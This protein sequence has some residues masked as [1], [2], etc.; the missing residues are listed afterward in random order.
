MRGH[1]RAPRAAHRSRRVNSRRGAAVDARPVGSFRSTSRFGFIPEAELSHAVQGSE[2]FEDLVSHLQDSP[3]G[4][5]MLFAMAV[6]HAV[7]AA[8]AA[9]FVRQL[10]DA[11]KAAR[12]AAIAQARHPQTSCIVVC[13]RGNA[14]DNLPPAVG[15]VPQPRIG[16]GPMRFGRAPSRAQLAPV[17]GLPALGAL[18][19]AWATPGGVP[20]VQL[21]ELGWLM[22]A[23]DR[24]SG[25]GRGQRP[26]LAALRQ[27]EE[28][29]RRVPHHL[30]PQPRRPSH[31]ERTRH[32]HTRHAGSSRCV[33]TR[34]A[35]RPRLAPHPPSACTR[36]RLAPHPPSARPAPAARPAPSLGSPRA[37]GLPRTL[38]RLAPAL[39]S[40]RALPRPRRAPS[41]S[42]IRTALTPAPADLSFATVGVARLTFV[43]E[44]FGITVDGVRRLGINFPSGDIAA[45]MQAMLEA[46]SIFGAT[47]QLHQSADGRAARAARRSGPRRLHPRARGAVSSRSL[48]TAS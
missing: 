23:T 18:E 15:C 5:W 9:F 28:R 44:T 35:P 16:D 13:A 46:P 34:L 37:L 8:F 25:V 4:A 12:A 45:G 38:P 11:V 2:T 33:C 1:A 43:D 26:V 3:D 24:L 19:G 20:P 32:A 36:P 42:H 7:P 29:A 47:R 31:Q 10:R 40:P 27:R 30:L 6:G 41:L 14:D 22:V 21:S 39:G 17:A 48:V